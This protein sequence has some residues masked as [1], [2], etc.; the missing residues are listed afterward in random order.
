MSDLIQR[1]SARDANE[2]ELARVAKM[3]GVNRSEAQLFAA[4]DL[5][6]NKVVPWEVLSDRIDYLY[7]D[8]DLDRIA[9]S[10]RLKR[11]RPALRRFSDKLRA[12]AVQDPV[13]GPVEIRTHSRIGLE[14]ITPPEWLRRRR[15]PEKPLPDW[16]LREAMRSGLAI[17]VGV[18]GG[19]VLLRPGQRFLSLKSG[20]IG[21][22]YLSEAEAEGGDQ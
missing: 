12:L 1:L 4:L 3:L 17:V 13:P 15:P 22:T 6:P 7:G 16:T 18:Q 14:L 8:Q 5:T 2:L 21:V 10:G 19:K 9:M 20:R 11:L